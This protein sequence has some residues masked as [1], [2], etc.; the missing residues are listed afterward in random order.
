MIMILGLFACGGLKGDLLPDSKLATAIWEAIGKPEGA[1]AP[2]D[3]EEFVT[4]LAGLEYCINLTE[5]D[6]KH[7]L[8]SDISPLA[9]L[10]IMLLVLNSVTLY[11][12]SDG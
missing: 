10:T 4:D 11:S 6:L 8:I 2:S 12:L 9:N 5:F 3:L 1:I 7:N